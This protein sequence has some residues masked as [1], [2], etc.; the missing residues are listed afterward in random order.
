MKRIYLDHAATT[1]TH[2][3]VLAEMRPYFSERFGNPS[4]IHSF[5][6]EARAAVEKAREQV[7]GLIGGS[8]QEIVFTSGGTESD[9]FALHGAL[10]ANMSKGDHIITSAIEHHAVLETCKFLEKHGAQV[11]YLPVDKYGLVDP[12]DVGKAITDKTIL[13]SVM[14]ANNEI[15]TIEPIEEI[16]KILND[17]RGTKD[18]GRKIYFHTDAVQTV[19][20]IPVDVNKLGVDLLSISSHK[21]YGPKGVGALY[22]K[23][24]TRIAPFL[25]GGG[26]ER[27]RR[28][29]TENVPG[30][31][32]FGKACELARLE[33]DARIKHLLPLRD[34][35]LKGIMARIPDVLLNGHPDKRLPKNVDV[36]VKYVEGES[37]LLNLDMAGIAVSTGSAC[38][39]GSLEPS[40]VLI[41]TGISPELAHGSVRFTLG[42]S[43]T[44][45]D[46][47]Y[48]LEV[49]PKIV[50]KLRKMSPLGRGKGKG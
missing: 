23:K 2:P 18:E 41:A 46:I 37:M 26:Q 17:R 36:T 33:L 35:L 31:V 3:E 45:A 47:D 14:H 9:N 22:I 1:P 7:A 48:V 27:N 50:E 20:G 40:H 42:R 13:V 10:I 29:T 30:I 39:S 19:G 12:Q 15:G 44:E 43:T 25:R 49:F 11:T 6:Q 28:A 5:G 4:S 32:G 38:S 21:L 8:V 34:K 16:S 24:G